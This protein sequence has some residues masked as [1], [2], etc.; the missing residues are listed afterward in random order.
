MRI[1][2]F[3]T[4]D[5][6]KEALCAIAEA[7]HEIAAVVTQPDRQRGRGREMSFSPVKEAAL[8]RGWRILQPVRVREEETVRA[9]KEAG[10]ELF[11]VAAFGQ[12]LPGEVL[13]IPPLGCINIHAS[14]LPLLRGAAPIQQAIL[15][16]YTETGITIMQMDEGCDTGDILSQVR[17]PI[18]ASDTGG[19]LFDKLS[20]AGA[21]EIVRMLPL[22]G[23]G[24]VTHIP[25]DETRATMSQKLTK[26]CG[27]IDWSRD[28]AYLDRLVR[29]CTP[30]PGAYTTW[31]GKASSVTD[32]NWKNTERNCLLE[33]KN[34][35]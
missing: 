6:A 30:W 8:E 16:G 20:R 23:Q 19:S 27:R 31:N 26:A 34:S 18:G 1:V 7:G 24:K 28:A 33:L 11:V 10:A 13:D 14:L 35:I 25:Q 9:L 2:F 5:F 4:P 21:E 12:I 32:R 17:V 29:A 3:G 22:I 15:E